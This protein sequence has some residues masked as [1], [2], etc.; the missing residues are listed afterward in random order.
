[1]LLHYL[2]LFRLLVISGRYGGGKTALAVWLAYQLSYPRILSNIS[3]S[4]P[5][6]K[7]I[8]DCGNSFVDV[9]SDVSDCVVVYDESWLDLGLGASFSKVRDYLS[10]LRKRNQV[11]LLPSVL[12]LSRTVRVFECS[13]VFNGLMF[14]I[15]LWLYQYRVS[16]FGDSGKYF[17]WF[18]SRV[19]KFYDTREY[20]GSWRLYE[21]I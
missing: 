21:R 18:P 16:S 20:P 2:Q 14:G 9:A 4:L 3:L 12:P 15:P 8:A 5:G 6:Y 1:M 7:F 13:R 19:F 10:F 17:F 11:L